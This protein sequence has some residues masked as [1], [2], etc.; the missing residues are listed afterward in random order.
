M[1]VRVFGDWAGRSTYRGT[2]A[3]AAAP[4][5]GDDV[6]D[7]VGDNVGDEKLKPLTFDNPLELLYAWSGPDGVL[8]GIYTGTPPP[9]CCSR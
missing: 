2:T 3:A 9:C 6:G 4:V 1:G 7:D 5:V 8:Y